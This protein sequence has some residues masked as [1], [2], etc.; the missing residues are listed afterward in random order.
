M[1]GVSPWA[2]W[3]FGLACG[4]CVPFL[5]RLVYGRYRKKWFRPSLLRLDAGPGHGGK[6]AK[7]SRSVIDNH[8]E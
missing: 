2:L 5:F 3:L 1:R 7:K 4:A 6:M 8:S